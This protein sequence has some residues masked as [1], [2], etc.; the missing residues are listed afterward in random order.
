MNLLLPSEKKDL[1]REL[2][3][4][5]ESG[6]NDI[7]IMNMFETFISQRTKHEPT[8]SDMEP[9]TKEQI[10][11]VKLKVAFEKMHDVYRDLRKNEFL[12][13]GIP[14]PIKNHN[15]SFSHEISFYLFMECLEG[16]HNKFLQQII[17]RT[18]ETTTIPSV[19]KEE[20][21]NL[22]GEEYLIA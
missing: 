4:I 10:E 9:L 8:K 11:Y 5:F 3:H 14:K 15:P 16:K 7:R 13:C 1:Q 17:D 2:D 19:P 21:A 6:A 22:D 12:F 20:R 18:K